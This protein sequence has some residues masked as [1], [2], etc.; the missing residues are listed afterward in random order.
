MPDT[1]RLMSLPNNPPKSV[2]SWWRAQSTA[3]ALLN[4]AH[5]KI[6]ESERIIAE[7]EKRIRQL[8]DLAATD[9]LTG[10]MNRR[11]FETF[12]DHE[13]ARIRRGN[14]PGAL[15]VLIDLDRFKT[16]NDTYGHL[17]GD[18]CL[19]I[20]AANLMSSIRFVDGA[21]R[22]GGDEFALLLTQT[23]PE[24]ALVCVEKIRDVLNKITLNWEGRELHFGASLGVAALDT[25]SDYKTAYTAADA[26]LYADKNAR[27]KK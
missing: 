20:V 12:F 26:G 15:M 10:L 23:D 5:E 3:M 14:S 19:N 8:E 4:Q 6:E 13:L 18:A 24:K 22:F 27:Q 7:Q 11:G 25:K 9:P 21:A 17:A 1:V 2:E 16:I